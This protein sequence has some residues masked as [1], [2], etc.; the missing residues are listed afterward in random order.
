MYSFDNILCE[1]ASNLTELKT[2]PLLDNI[3]GSYSLKGKPKRGQQLS[4]FCHD[5]IAEQLVQEDAQNLCP[6]AIVG[7]GNCLFR[8]F[9]TLF[10]RKE[11]K[12][13]IDLR[14]RTAI[15]VYTNT[16]VIRPSKLWAHRSTGQSQ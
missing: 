1:L 16:S 15:E 4:M 3:G 12:D 10:S 13:Y 9:S 14:V 11:R 6:V 2:K 5:T 8:T 7:D